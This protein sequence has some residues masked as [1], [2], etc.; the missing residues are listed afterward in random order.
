M[1]EYWIEKE[2]IFKLHDHKGTLTVYWFKKPSEQN[3]C[4][5]KNAWEFLGETPEYVEHV[6]VTLNEK[7]L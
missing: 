3:K 1:V 4:I 7:M 6:I 5:L 2:E